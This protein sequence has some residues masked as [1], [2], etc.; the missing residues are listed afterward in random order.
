LAVFALMV[1]CAND[2][3]AL[4]LDTEFHG[5]LQSTFVSRDTDEFQHGVLDECRGVQWRNGLK[6]DKVSESYSKALEILKDKSQSM[7]P[8]KHGLM[9]V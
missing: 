8:K 3:H 6:F 1:F 9:P 7:A 2:V 5:R 4:Q